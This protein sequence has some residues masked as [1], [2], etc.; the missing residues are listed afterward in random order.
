MVCVY[1]RYASTAAMRLQPLCVYSRYA[2]TAGR[3]LQPVC[4]GMALGTAGTEAV[5]DRRH[6]AYR[7][8]HAGAWRTW[9]GRL[10][11]VG[12]YSRGMAHMDR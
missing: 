7:H 10:Q 8:G 11:P 3:R 2:S 5:R 12:V 9:T 4:I 6:G 1:S